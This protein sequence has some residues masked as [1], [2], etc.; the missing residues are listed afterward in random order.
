MTTV[1]FHSF[2]MTR[3][4][5][6][7]FE[8]VTCLYNN[9]LMCRKRSASCFGAFPFDRC[10]EM[11]LENGSVLCI[12]SRAYNLSSV[13]SFG[14]VSGLSVTLVISCESVSD[15][16]CG[17]RSSVVLHCAVLLLVWKLGSIMVGGKEHLNCGLPVMW[18]FYQ[19][20]ETVSCFVL[21]SQYPFEGH[22]ICCEF[23]PPSVHFVIGILSI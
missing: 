21:G 10:L 14:M 23:L 2:G 12:Y 16:S 20:G 9:A 1:Y 17:V 15:L 19:S 13:S 11:H 7:W 4:Q 5:N 3:A 18:K 6:F 8:S 22:V